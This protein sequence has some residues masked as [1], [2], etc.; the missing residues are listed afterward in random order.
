M[1][2]PALA[3][4]VPGVRRWLA[5]VLASQ[6]VSSATCGDAALVVS[7]L[8]TNAV[9]HGD[10]EVVVRSR[11]ADH[12]VHISV[13]DDGGGHPR[14]AKRP[15]ERIGGLGLHIVDQVAK[16]WGVDPVKP[17]RTPG[18]TVWAVLDDG[19]PSTWR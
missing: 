1:V 15:P 16:R 13:T 5:A 6:G 8:V 3:A 14:L 17:G 12:D 4:E 9:V 7:E 2:V 11:V 10:G 18:K 19:G